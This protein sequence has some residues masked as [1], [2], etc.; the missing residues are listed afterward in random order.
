MSN[1][2]PLAYVSPE[3]KLGNNVTISAFAYIDRNV[4]IGDNCVISPHVSILSGARIGKNNRI[5]D[6]SIISATPQDFRWKG[7]DSFVEIGENNTIREHVIINRSIHAGKAT[8]I[9]SNSFIMA[10]THVGHDSVIGSYV[11]L[12]NAVK[13]A[14]SCKIGDF[15]ILSSNALV[16]ENCEVGQWVLVKG[17]CRVNNNVPPFTVMAHNPIEYYG[18][19]AYVLRKGKKSESVIDDIAKCYRHVYQTATSPF[20]ALLRIESDVEKSD[21]RDMIVDFI[22]NHDYK[23][24]ALPPEVIEEYKD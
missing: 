12:G 8:R 4:E 11:V 3:A 21:E 10:Q 1:I 9:G 13:I 15:C 22:R 18:V 17:G 5:L 24:A 19:N 14:G 23:I 16:H 20:N 7:E 2:S 6:G